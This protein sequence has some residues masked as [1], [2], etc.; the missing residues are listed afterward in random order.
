MT[1]AQNPEVRERAVE[2][3]GGKIP[4]SATSQHGDLEAGLCSLCSRNRKQVSELEQSKTRVTGHNK[5]RETQGTRMYE[6]S[7]AMGRT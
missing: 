6:A 4:G 2:I 7:R 5:G 3:Y 1:L